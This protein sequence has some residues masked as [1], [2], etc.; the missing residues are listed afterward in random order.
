MYKAYKQRKKSIK[1]NACALCSIFLD[2]EILDKKQC[3]FMN[4]PCIVNTEREV[5]Y[6]QL[7]YEKLTLDQKTKLYIALLKQKK[8]K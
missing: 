5:L 2:P 4:D 1:V 7:L 3:Q 8:L 6:L